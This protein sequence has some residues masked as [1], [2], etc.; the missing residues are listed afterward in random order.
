MKRVLG[1]MM[2][3]AVLLTSVANG[4]ASAEP[5]NVWK[6]G[7]LNLNA[8]TKEQLVEVGVDSSF[9]DALLE[10]REE[11]EAFVDMDELLDI[12]GVTPKK[13]RELKK[14]LFVE[15]LQGCGC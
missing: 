5:E 8:A 10:A 9:A 11:S 13:M 15:E 3:L 1:L 6:D 12:D 4:F 14:I 2:V 7:K